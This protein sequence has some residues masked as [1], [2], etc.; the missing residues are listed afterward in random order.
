MRK[1]RFKKTAYIF[2]S[3]VFL[4]LFLTGCEGYVAKDIMEGNFK[5]AMIEMMEGHPWESAAERRAKDKTIIRESND[6]NTEIVLEDE[7]SNIE[8]PPKEEKSKKKKKEAAQKEESASK[9]KLV[10]EDL[11]GKSS[12]TRT[13][14]DEQKS[15]IESEDNYNFYYHQLN[16]KEKDIYAQLMMIVKKH[17]DNDVLITTDI[18]AVDKIFL[19]VVNDHPEIF[20][21]NGYS[22]SEYMIGNVTDSLDFRPSYT[23]TAHE[24]DSLMNRVYDYESECLAMAPDGDDYT[25]IKYVYDY[26]IKNTEYNLNAEENQNILSVFLNG[27]SVCQ[28]YAKSAQYLLQRMH[29]PC[30]LVS[31]TVNSGESHAWNLVKSNGKWYYLDTTWG[32]AS[33]KGNASNEAPEVNY[34]YLCTNSR[35]M[36][37]THRLKSKYNIPECDSLDDYY[38]VKEGTYFTWFDEDKLKN[39]IV[40]YTNRGESRI[41][42]K[43]EGA[44]VY[45]EMIS[46]L[47]EHG[48]IADYIY[49][50]GSVNYIRMD[51]SFNLIIYL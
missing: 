13:D 28:G 3:L 8:N 32:D 50:A 47:F 9:E 24:V 20:Y 2:L 45:H 11:I 31:G 49:G 41:N 10:K 7:S 17:M 39:L 16:D 51:D 1:T 14:L 4:C 15:A 40:D 27:S 48:K 30:I 38:Y 36:R 29:I 6:G 42:I 35:W 5:K 25:K 19:C 33:Y 26:I 37:K 18:D 34:D 44:A 23:K 46:T 43:C 12:F 21:V 22:M